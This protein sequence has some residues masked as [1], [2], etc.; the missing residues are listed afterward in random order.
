MKVSLRWAL[1]LGFLGLIWGTHLITTSSSF[2]TS[3]R[4][5]NQH[6][7]NI[8]KNI[9]NLAMEQSENHIAHAQEAALLAKRLLTADVVSNAEDRIAALE[10]YFLDQ[11]AI[12]PH[13]AGIYL[14]TPA[15]NFYDVRRHNGRSQ[16]GYRT[17]II[18]HTPDGSRKVHLI[19]R[20]ASLAVIARE[21]D[22]GDRYDPRVRPW[23]SRAIDTN[24]I[25]W[26]DPYIFYTSQK[27]GIT[28]AGPVYQ[29]TGMLKGVVGVDIEI[30]Q[31]STFI[32][33][34]EISQH[35]RAFMLNRN[36]DVIAFPDLEKLKF[37][38]DNASDT[39]LA[40]IQELDDALSRRTFEAAGFPVDP[41]GNFRIDERIFC[42]FDF[43]G[44]TYH[45]M[46]TPFSTPEWPWVIGVHLPED[47]YLGEIKANRR[48]N[49][50]ITVVISGVA[51]LIGLLLS[52]GII[53]PLSSL[54]KKSLAM[55]RGE[56]RPENDAPIHSMYK[57]IQA[58]FGAFTSMRAKVEASQLKYRSI[59]ENIQ[60][61]Y[62]ESTIDG[63]LL[64]ISPSVER[65]SK[66]NRKELIGSSIYELY[67]DPRERDTTMHYLLTE[68]KLNDYEIAL[69]DKDGSKQYGSFNSI[70]VRDAQNQ[71]RKVI[72]SMRLITDRKRIDQELSQYRDHLEDLVKQRTTALEEANTSLRKE[73]EQHKQT[74][75]ALRSSEERYRSILENI[76]EGY[77]ETDI[78]GNLTFVNDAAFRIMGYPHDE[79]IGLNNR[80]YTS[81]ETA[82]RLYKACNKVYRTGE[83]TQ[84]TNYAVIC[85]DGTQKLLELS[86]SLIQN[87]GGRPQGFRGVARDITQRIEAEEKRKELE[88]QLHQ[89]QRMEAIGT[90]AGGIAHDFNNLLMGIQGSISLLGQNLKAGDP[91][92]HCMQTIEHCVES[93]ANLTRQLL[94]F[95]RGGKYVVVPVDLNAT[96]RK[97]SEL[98]GRTKKEIRIHGDYAKNLWTVKADQGQIEQVLV[99]LYV[100]AW[101]AMDERG[102]IYLSTQNVTLD[103]RYTQ[104]YGVEPGKYVKVTVQD[105]GQG[106]DEKTRQHIFEPFFTTKKIGRGT[107]LGL[108]SAF[109][110]IKNHDGI[111]DVKSVVGQGS[112]FYIYLPASHKVMA[113]SNQATD[114]IMTGS[115]TIL[116]VDDE[117]FIVQSL[118]DMLS[119]LG[120]NTIGA[121]GGAEAIRIVEDDRDT[122]DLVILDMIM[123]NMGGRETYN[124]LKQIRPT[125]KVL[126]SSG[127]SLN[128]IAQDIMQKGC[129]GF[130]QK[131]FRLS[132]LS[133][134]VRKILDKS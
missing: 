63:T 6:A 51:T 91:K 129:D 133:Q 86:V 113:E 114:E 89:A 78:A 95:A 134:M 54:E 87:T 88:N 22:H 76:Q 40:K 1:I 85:K 41:G 31:L 53:G 82:R 55:Q 38:A 17:K 7:Q 65:I 128:S 79:L 121:D 49:I 132:K 4:V 111:I 83:P 70:L 18:S 47:D 105:T 106:M 50:W 99:N 97:T 25:V 62:Y 24:E 74:S 126:L 33:N 61:C 116:L 77:Y 37:V 48:N 19:W 122:I 131:P 58:T 125:L 84:V 69:R 118:Q 80:E 123:P 127:Y 96:L 35:G 115:E 102:D 13:L 3:Q 67:H 44:K 93:G 56:Y 12:Y 23:Y 11:L 112:T 10:R 21:T 117:P 94:G 75:R 43:E 130:I 9:G 20:N 120:Y 98:F 59:F 110:I 16:G 14:G 27:P 32:A 108:A 101:Q 81:Q 92:Y 57:E 45:A 72:G 8:M 28:I 36:G 66:Y 5:L 68:G 39:R 103:S 60:D 124:R 90:L 71:P 73:I 119:R 2:I 64:E 46:F 26:T 109:G 29:P 107:G 52:R 15:G 34:L 42:R 30:D 104:P 100:N